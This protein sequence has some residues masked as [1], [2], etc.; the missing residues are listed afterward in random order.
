MEFDKTKVYTAVNA[1]EV[2]I[3]S[4]GYFA[5]SIGLLK[6]AVKNER[7]ANYGKI[8]SISDNEYDACRFIII[9]DACYAFFYLV[10]EPKEKKPRPYRD[11]AEMLYDFKD[12]FDLLSHD[13]RL[14]S[15][16]IKNKITGVCNMVIRI[17]NDTATIV[18]NTDVVTFS[19][20]SLFES[21][22]YLD[23]SVTGL[24]KEEKYEN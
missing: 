22:T 4:K 17:A 20:E 11:T 5:D 23:G 24:I 14:P 9:D 1:D 21:Y 12:R 16:W 15:I 10:E 13:D 6:E 7:K 18:S 3:G 2:K 8:E 19:M